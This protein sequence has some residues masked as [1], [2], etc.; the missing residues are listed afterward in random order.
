MSESLDIDALLQ[1]QPSTTVAKQLV[2]WA[3]R[4]RTQIARGDMML[5]ILT[6][7]DVAKI[8]VA[9]QTAAQQGESSAWVT[10]AWWFGRPGDDLRDWRRCRNGLRICP[11]DVR[12]GGL[13]WP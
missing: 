8:P 10:L 12:S 1:S 11:R 6:I 2:A 4:T 9:Y 13:L 5:G 7:D 3:D